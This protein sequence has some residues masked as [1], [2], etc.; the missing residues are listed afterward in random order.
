MTFGDEQ[1]MLAVSYQLYRYSTAILEHWRLADP[2]IARVIEHCIVAEFQIHD[3][4][5]T[6]VLARMRPMLDE[7]RATLTPR[8]SGFVRL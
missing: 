6:E 5:D 1:R 8:I 2:Y 3:E 7:G 4:R